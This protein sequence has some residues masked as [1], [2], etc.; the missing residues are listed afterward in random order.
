[1]NV[2]FFS[3]HFRIQK[4][5]IGFFTVVPLLILTAII[6]VPDP[7]C[8]G[9]GEISNTGMSTVTVLKID[10]SLVSSGQYDACLSF[11]VFTYNVVVTLQNSAKEVT[12]N[13]YLLVAL[14]DNKTGKVL[15]SQPVIATVPPMQQVQNFFTVTFYLGSDPPGET[16]VVAATKTDAQPCQVCGGTGKVSLNALLLAKFQKTAYAQVQLVQAMT[17]TQ[18]DVSLSPEELLGMEGTTDQWYIEH[19]PGSEDTENPE[20]VTP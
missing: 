7:V 17:I 3:S 18:P 1:M 6:R 12:G 15:G 2:K 5:Y 20:T 13:G 4:K 16:R 9:A 8:D 14:I 10:S 19:P 11:R